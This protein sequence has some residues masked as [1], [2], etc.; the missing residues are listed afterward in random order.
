MRRD[1]ASEHGSVKGESS[2][3]VFF[4]CKVVWLLCKLFEGHMDSFFLP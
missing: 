3:Y 1:D 4:H 2:E